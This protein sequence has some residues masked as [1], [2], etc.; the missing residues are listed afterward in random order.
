MQG[1]CVC[2]NAPYLRLGTGNVEIAGLFAPKPLAMIGAKDWTIDIETKGYP[3]LQALYRLYGAEAN[4][5]AKCFPQFGHNYNQVSREL[6]YAWFNAHLKLGQ[7]E[8]VR[9]RSFVPIPPRELSVFDAEHP[10][11]ADDLDAAGVRRHLAEQDRGQLDALAPADAARLAEFRRVVGTAL[12]EMIHDILP[13]AD[14]VSHEE[15]APKGEANGRIARKLWLGRR[16]GDE[17]VPA[18]AVRGPQFD[19][20]VVVWVHPSGK[21][22]L[23]ADGQP[24]PELQALLDGGTAV[25][26]IDVVGTGELSGVPPSVNATYA[27]FTFGYNRPLFAEQ[28]HDVLTAIVAAKNHPSAKHVHLVGWGAAGPVA[29]AAR[30]LSGDAVARTAVDLDHFRFEDV[31]AAGEPRMLPGA[32]KY[33][34]LDG[35][36]ALCAPHELML[37]NHRGTGTGRLAQA[38]YKAAGAD[39]KLRREPERLDGRQVIEWLLRPTDR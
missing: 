28:V 38:A 17:K 31:R 16:G 24:T 33:G 7:T 36:A 18:Y 32:L 4:V 14:D 34:G 21:S 37:V 13:A 8:P 27:G 20:D 22:S 11:P 9:E 30:A 15:A 2:E 29:L 12:R 39:A 3:E 10:R 26:A 35:F 25:V 19:G 5:F 6:T 23:F 1:G